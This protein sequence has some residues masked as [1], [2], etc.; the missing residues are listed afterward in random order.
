MLPG[1]GRQLRKES[2]HRS[3]WR[4]GR[5]PSRLSSFLLRPGAGSLTLRPLLPL[6]PGG[7][8]VPGSPGTPWKR[9]GKQ[10]MKPWK[11]TCSRGSQG[12]SGLLSHGVAAAC[13]SPADAASAHGPREGHLTQPQRREADKGSVSGPLRFVL[14]SPV[15][16]ACC[17]LRRRDR[18]ASQTEWGLGRARP[19]GS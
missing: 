13:A 1:A 17:H 4:P 10:R 9:A 6:G 18:G 2:V 15:T 5:P 7:P 14:T 12:S 8:A 16:S 11:G 3:A 19:L